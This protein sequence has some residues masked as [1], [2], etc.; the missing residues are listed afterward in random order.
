[1]D[2]EM[3]GEMSDMS[4]EID[5]KCKPWKKDN[6]KFKVPTN[7]KFK[8][9]SE[10]MDGFNIKEATEEAETMANEFICNHCKNFPA[11]EIEECLGGVVCD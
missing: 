7:I 4:K 6:S 11:E 1:M 9:M 2:E 3:K 5:Y 8:D 10:M